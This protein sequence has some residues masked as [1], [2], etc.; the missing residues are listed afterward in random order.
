MIAIFRLLNMETQ[1]AQRITEE[2]FSSHASLSS[3]DLLF[4]EASA[5]LATNINKNDI[6]QDDLIMHG[7]SCVNI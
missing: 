4:R 3:M 7:E 2:L 1:S 6:Y 5:G